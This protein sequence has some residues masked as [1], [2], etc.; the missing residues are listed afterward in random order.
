MGKASIGRIKHELDEPYKQNMPSCQFGAVAGGG[1]DFAHH[2]IL[3]VIAYAAELSLSLFSLFVDLVK[4]FDKVLRELVMGF[5]QHVRGDRLAYLVTRGLSH[6]EASWI[7]DYIEKHG[8]AFE[9]WGVSPKVSALVNG[10]HSKAWASYGECDSYIVSTTGGRQGCKLGGIVFNEAYALALRVLYDRLA[11][12]NIVLRLKYSK[13]PFWAS[14]FS[15]QNP[16]EQSVIDATFI[17][18]EAIALVSASPR[19]FRD[20]IKILVEILPDT[21]R[22]FR[23]Q[24]NWSP[25]KTEAMMV[26]RGKHATEVRESFRSGGKL[27]VQIPGSAES[28]HIVDYC[29]HLG[30][31]TSANRSNVPYDK[32]RASTAMG[33]YSPLAVKVF[34]S[35]NLGRWLKNVFLQSLVVSTLLFNA[36]IRVLDGRSLD[37]S[38]GVYM[39]AVRRIAGHVRFEA[40]GLSDLE[41]RRIACF[42]SVD[43]LIQRARN[44][45]LSCTACSL[46]A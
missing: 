33:A 27:C 24:I 21:F 2:V 17:D 10:L 13:G 3:S 11:D 25:G 36:H 32:D 42:S 9:Q 12:A 20:A 31:V 15:H 19:A 4:A 39:R 40:G 41:V 1:T 26:W 35:P 6:T 28:L 37:I 16:C 30:S 43:C 46:S 18:D 8:T 45:P 22:K 29:K 7:C 34:G 44:Y 38:N 5:P 14:Q 23:L